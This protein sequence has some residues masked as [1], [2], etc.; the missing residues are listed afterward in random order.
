MKILSLLSQPIQSFNF[1]RIP[2]LVFG[3][4]SFNNIPSLLGQYG[5]SVLIVTGKS[6]HKVAGR[7]DQLTRKLREASI[8]FLHVQV[9]GEPSPELVDESV[10]TFREKNINV[11][12]AWGGG[13]VVDAGKAISA[14][15]REGG[16]VVDYLE[17]VGTGAKHSGVK[18]PMIAMPT[19]AGTG[20]EATKNAVLSSVGENGFKKSLRHDNFVPDIAV[21]DPQLM[22][23]CPA[24]VT[25]ACGLDAFTQLLEA[26]V[27]T[28]ASPLTDALALSGLAY[29]KDCLVPAAT[30]RA[31]DEHVRAGM[32]YAALMSGIVL[33]NA[34]LGVVHGLASPVGGFFDIP[35]GVVCGTLV[36]KATRVTIEK[37]HKE[38][39][40]G[41]IALQKY[42]A[43][44]ALL[45]DVPA[46]GVEEGCKLLLETIDHWLDVLQT[47]RLSKYGISENDFEKIITGT[48]NKNNPLPLTDLEIREVLQARL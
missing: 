33:A 11:V 14:M 21:V 15:L 48:G 10:A 29:V 2:Q 43:V 16:S 42:A 30:D 31:D 12:L 23:S 9:S 7:W 3:A 37:L 13:S 19:T 17:G 6:S 24:H 46:A 22:V 44:G 40:N 8:D 4:G 28:K 25:A 36:G 39:G 26:Y 41:S 38:E 32:A 35:H 1:A 5:K 18:V 20:S 45:A 27:A 34:G 47:P